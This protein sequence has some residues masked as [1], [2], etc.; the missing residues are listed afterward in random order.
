MF[1]TSTGKHHSERNPAVADCGCSGVDVVVAVAPHAVGADS[2]SRPK[3]FPP[4]GGGFLTSS[5]LPH[6]PDDAPV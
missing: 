2:M 3:P 1:P 4:G 6:P 5:R